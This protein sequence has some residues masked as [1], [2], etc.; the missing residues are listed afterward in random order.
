M[1]FSPGNAVQRSHV[2]LRVRALANRSNAVFVA[3]NYQ[4]AP[5][6]PYPT[7]LNDAD[8]TLRWIVDNSEALSIDPN[9]IGVVGDSAG[10]NLAT[11]LCLRYQDENGP[12]IVSQVLVYPVCDCSFDTPSYIENATGYL[13]ERD[14]MR[15]YVDQYLTDPAQVA[16]PVVSLLRAP[17]LRGLPRALVIS[18]EYDP[19]RDEAEAYAERLADAGVQVRLSRYDGMVHGF[20]W[21]A[22]CIDRALELYD[23]IARE[24]RDTLHA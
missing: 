4:K 6:H 9:R 18:A 1:S 13:L 8:A 3:L 2:L 17:D 24:L 16:D 15:W 5:E 20:A 7:A 12:R 10:G 19:L 21:M 14:E 11:A 22:G 23:E